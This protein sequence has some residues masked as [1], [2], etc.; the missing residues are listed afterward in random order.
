MLLFYRF[1]YVQHRKDVKSTRKKAFEAAE[2]K[3]TEIKKT[4]ALEFKPAVVNTDTD[5]DLIKQ[6]IDFKSADI[7]EKL[8]CD[9]DKKK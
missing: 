1:F 7:T 3:E 4:Q 8:D 5:I 2:K 6:P 9:I